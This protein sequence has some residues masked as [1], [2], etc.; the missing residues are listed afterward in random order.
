M[1]GTIRKTRN[2]SK[3]YKEK[4][5]VY[6]YWS[7]VTSQTITLYPTRQSGTSPSSVTFTFNQLSRVDGIKQL[8]D[9]NSYMSSGTYAFRDYNIS[10][11][12]SGNTVIVSGLP[13]GFT[14]YSG[15]TCTAFM[16][17]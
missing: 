5:L 3:K 4:N 9:I 2:F 17:N 7:E 12:I 16:I 15:F 6:F 1:E 14:Y 8:K 13:S 11:T 10:I